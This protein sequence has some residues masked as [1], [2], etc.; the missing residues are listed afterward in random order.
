MVWD[1]HGLST[2]AKNAYFFAGY[3]RLAVSTITFGSKITVQKQG[4]TELGKIWE[5]GFGQDHISIVLLTKWTWWFS[6]VLCMSLPESMM[7]LRCFNGAFSGVSRV[8][9]CICKDCR[10]RPDA[11]TSNPSDAGLPGLGPCGPCG[12]CGPGGAAAKLAATVTWRR[13]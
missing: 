2:L 8:P 3:L 13:M 1:Y 12:P 11:G 4:W 9:R 6:I 10:E 7:F 5:C